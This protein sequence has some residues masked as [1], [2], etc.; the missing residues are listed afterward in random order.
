M[1]LRT[2]AITGW[3]ENDDGTLNVTY[4]VWINAQD[5][6]AVQDDASFQ[7][8]K[9][10]LASQGI[11]TASAQPNVISQGPALVN[12]SK[13]ITSVETSVEI[14]Q[15]LEGVST[16]THARLSY[17]LLPRLPELLWTKFKMWTSKKLQ[18]GMWS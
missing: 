4:A 9:Q 14:E 8:L 16:R 10:R 11:E 6:L 5:A 2:I 3:V 17:G 12:V 13:V 7:A 18:T 1:D 15:T